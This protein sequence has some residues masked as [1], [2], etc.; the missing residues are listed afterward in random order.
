MVIFESERLDERGGTTKERWR[1]TKKKR[2]HSDNGQPTTP[3]PQRQTT[4]A[5]KRRGRTPTKT[6]HDHRF[7]PTNVHQNTKATT[8]QYCCVFLFAFICLQGRDHS[9]LSK[10]RWHQEIEGIST[11]AYLI[12]FHSRKLHLDHPLI[13]IIGNQNN[14]SRNKDKFENIDDVV[15]VIV[16]FRHRSTFL[17]TGRQEQRQEQ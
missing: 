10:Y 9:A 6:P 13:I 12:S 14:A 7:K 11:L 16:V 2:K 4:T 17:A 15:D 1:G 5:T 3:P 8:L